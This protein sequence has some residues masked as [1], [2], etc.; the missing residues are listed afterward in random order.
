MSNQQP[1]RRKFLTGAAVAAT[2]AA[3]LGFPGIVKAQGP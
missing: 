2:G 1:S 3:T